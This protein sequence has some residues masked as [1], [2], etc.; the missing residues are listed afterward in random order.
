MSKSEVPPIIVN[1]VF[2]DERLR[3]IE[4]LGILLDSSIPIGKYRIGLDPI[5]GLIP[6]IGD[7]IG[8]VLSSYIVFEAAKLGVSKV[9][10]VRMILNITVDALIGAIPI[11]G[12]LSDFVFK[13]NQRNLALLRTSPRIAPSELGTKRLGSVLIV[14][15][16]FLVLL[17]GLV[18]YLMLRVFGAVIAQLS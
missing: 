14:L 7:A 5:L 11:V 16:L 6:G 18:L 4:R 1:Q 2:D 8:T 3:R 13:S 12:D 9:T 15:V 10:L 17:F